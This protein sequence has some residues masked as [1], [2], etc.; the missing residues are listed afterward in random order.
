MKQGT[1]TNEAPDGVVIESANESMDASLASALSSGEFRAL[2]DASPDL[3]FLTDGARIYYLNAAAARFLGVTSAADCEGLNFQGIVSG[4]QGERLQRAVGEVHTGRPFKGEVTLTRHDGAKVAFSAAAYPSASERDGSRLFAATF[5]DLTTQKA[6]ELEL[7]SSLYVDELTG[8]A[9]RRRFIEILA[10]SIQEN[11]EGAEIGLVAIDID[12]FKVLN[13]SLGPAAGDR[14]LVAI[15]DRV[16]LAVRAS[17]LVTRLSGDEFVVLCCDLELDTLQSVAERIREALALPFTILR[18]KLTLCVSIGIVECSGTH[19]EADSILQDAIAAVALAKDRGGDQIAVFDPV[20]RLELASRLNLE[21]EL[22]Q[23]LRKSE[24]KLMYQKEVW[25]TSGDLVCLEALV[26]WEHPTRGLVPPDD[27]IPLAESTGLIVPL[28]DWV[29][30]EVCR[31]LRAWEQVGL[32]GMSV[33][34]NVSPRQLAEADF[35]T[36]VLAIL[37]GYG[38]SPAQINLEITESMMAED[39]RAHLRRV[40]ELRRCGVHDDHG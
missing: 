21:Q 17:D 16:Q 31:Q 7:K 9:N 26:R 22:R 1:R 20:R 37:N 30:A 12:R 38:I 32:A 23:A 33:S 34:I 3:V 39:T 14:L 19:V 15:S 5:H 6:Y 28:G 24:F 25:L 8:L 2:L 4:P 35:V 13:D 27:F 18:R 11:Q 29:I 36:R 40:H 10:Q